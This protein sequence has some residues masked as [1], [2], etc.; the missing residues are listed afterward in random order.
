MRVRRTSALVELGFVPV[1]VLLLVAE[2][3]A[4]A[5]ARVYTLEPAQSRLTIHVGK[6]GVFGFAGHEHEVVAGGFRGTA[7]FDPDRIAQSSVD[8]TFEA[9]ALRVAGQGEPAG[10][11]PQVQAAM[12]GATCL[13]AGRFPTIRFVSKSVAAAGAAGPKGADLALRGELTL[14]GVTRPL[15]L[16][17]HLDVTG[18]TL[19]ATGQTTLK[20]TDFG[21]TPISKA[22]VVKVKDELTLSWR[23]RGRTP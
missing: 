12:V 6:T 16:R 14:H 15:T 9:G 11:V 3:P 13:D 23:I 5:A 20:Q 2:A 7:T 4:Q 10:D 22:G 8:L 1:F 17:V 21:I 19:E 18:Q